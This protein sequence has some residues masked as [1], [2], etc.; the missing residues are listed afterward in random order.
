MSNFYTN[1]KSF[2]NFNEFLSEKFYQTVPSDWW[3]LISDVRDS[4]VAVMNGKYQDV[5]MVGA[6]GITAVCNE[7]HQTVP[8]MFGGDGAVILVP[9]EFKD[10][11]IVAFKKAIYVSK[12]MYGLNL[13]AG[14]IEMKD[15]IS[16]GGKIQVAKYELSENNYTAQFKGGG[17]Q[18]AEEL[19]K[20]APHYQLSAIEEMPNLDGL[21]CRW[22]PVVQKKGTILTLVIKSLC[23]NKFYSNIVNE[24]ETILGNSL[25]DA[26]PVK[27]S[28]LQVSFPPQHLDLE[29]KAFATKENYLK[30]KIKVWID[31]LIGYILIRYNFELKGF[32]SS[33]YKKEIVLNSDFK[34]FDDTLRMVIDC[35]KNQADQISA[36]LLKHENN[37]LAHFG[38]HQSDSAVLTCYVKSV[39]NDHIHFIDGHGGGYTLSA[40]QIKNKNK[41]ITTKAN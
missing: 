22:E 3:I 37:N 19:I 9:P 32:S 6:L 7:I 29:V 13:R 1:Q 20:Y 28:N 16:R 2:H 23:G 5:N 38:A 18:L 4:T 11:A 25:K 40:Q 35:T 21:S 15:I 12:E 27:L 36:I 34:K 14:A 10:Q 31:N 8:F 41:I 17:I 30:T 24:I 39:R 33:Q 26:S